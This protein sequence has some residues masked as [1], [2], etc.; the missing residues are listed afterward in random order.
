VDV[1]RRLMFIGFLH[2][3]PTDGFPIARLVIGAG[4]SLA[5]L[6]AS[7]VLLP[8]ETVTDNVLSALGHVCLVLL[9]L[10]CC[11][12]ML[13]NRVVA[14][15]G[16]ASSRSIL[17]IDNSLAIDSFI[18]A[19]PYTV[20]SA[21]ALVLIFYPL[22]F[23]RIPARIQV[24][25]TGKSVVLSLEEG[26]KFHI[27]LSHVWRTGQDQT[28]AI[29]RQLCLLLPGI[30]VFLDV[31][32]LEEIGALEQYVRETA[33]VLIFLSK[34][35]FRS[36]NCLRE[37]VASVNQ[38]KPVVL[39]W[40]PDPSKGGARVP[41][42]VNEL[43]ER[44]EALETLGLTPEEAEEYIFRTS[45]KDGRPIIPWHRIKDFQLMS[46]KMITQA[47]I[48]TSPAYALPERESVGSR[49]AEVVCSNAPELEIPDTVDAQKMFL[50]QPAI[51]YVSD[52][53][54]GAVAV[55]NELK[56]ALKGFHV[57]NK[58]PSATHF[59][60]YLS[61]DTFVGE[62]GRR[63]GEQVGALLE[64][65]VPCL[66][67]HEADDEKRHGCEFGHFFTTTPQD[68]IDSGIYNQLAITFCPGLHRR[69][70]YGLS[71]K[72]LGAKKLSIFE[73]HAQNLSEASLQ[74]R[75][76][77][78]QTLS[79]ASLQ[80]RHSARHSARRA[81]K[82]LP[83]QK[84]AALISDSVKSA[85]QRLPFFRKIASAAQQTGLSTAPSFSHSEGGAAHT[86]CCFPAESCSA[87]SDVDVP[88]STP[89]PHF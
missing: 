35:Y 44:R 21:M 49:R 15:N 74:A 52:L 78:R 31:D 83:V 6:F 84:R 59:L 87:S 7:L 76:S 70:S 16:F 57:T 77:A 23:A 2:F 38:K 47:M 89:S 24:K 50:M 27:F 33:V 14:E 48:S 56:R 72:A 69:V 40:E 86:G 85:V 18:T 42:L 53:N 1:L 79:E 37:V 34:G 29:K 4:I 36:F 25:Q 43:F 41:E 39:V 3:I 55:A 81:T 71:A 67:I 60:L 5:F 66:M 54:P 12:L 26:H 22:L 51:V 8:Y 80:A 10:S 68:L 9:L 11:L 58:P 63:F 46:L 75:H 32:D 64:R 13:Y 88:A 82:G 65:R 19:I 20:W 62:L 28:A 17:G 45:Q 30:S 61:T 73:Q